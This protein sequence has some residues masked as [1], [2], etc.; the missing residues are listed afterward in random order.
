LNIHR[1][2]DFVGTEIIFPTSDQRPAGTNHA[3]EKRGH[4]LYWQDRE[5]LA[6]IRQNNICRADSGI[7]EGHDDS[8]RDPHGAPRRDVLHWPQERPPRAA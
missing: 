6:I 4:N 5:V 8:F 1:I 7:V 2:D 3:V